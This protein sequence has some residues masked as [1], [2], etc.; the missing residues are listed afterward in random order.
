MSSTDLPE[1]KP[2]S[3]WLEFPPPD[4]DSFDAEAS[5]ISLHHLHWSHHDFPDNSEYCFSSL[6]GIQL[7]QFARGFMQIPKNER[8]IDSDY[9]DPLLDPIYIRRKLVDRGVIKEEELSSF[10]VYFRTCI[11]PS[12]AFSVPAFD[13]D[14]LVRLRADV[15]RVLSDS[16]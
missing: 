6:I 11:H 5:F 2:D 16:E 14:A 4:Q 9:T 13:D 12:M 8:I 1:W 3:E 10:S 15:K 7:D